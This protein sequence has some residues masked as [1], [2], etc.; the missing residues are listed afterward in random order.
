MEQRVL[1]AHKTRN[2]P[3]LTSIAAIKHRCSYT[4]MGLQLHGV[5]LLVVSMCL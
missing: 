1:P 5:S 3:A 4:D 2:N